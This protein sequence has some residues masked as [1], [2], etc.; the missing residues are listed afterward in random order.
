MPNNIILLH[1]SIAMRAAW[2]VCL[3]NGRFSLKPRPPL[4][5]S[6]CGNGLGKKWKEAPLEPNWADKSRGQGPWNCSKAPG[7]PDCALGSQSEAF[8]LLQSH[9]L[10]PRS[11][12][13]CSKALCDGS[14]TPEQ[15]PHYMIWGGRWALTVHILPRDANKYSRAG[16]ESQKNSYT[17]Q[18]HQL[19]TKKN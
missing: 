10:W 11:V 4:Q 5:L 14:L 8:A 12:P 19:S 9:P 2:Y 6:L 1:H 16:C 15:G 13:P 18:I 3:K 17:A 7:I